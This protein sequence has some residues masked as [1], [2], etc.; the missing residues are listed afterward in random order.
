MARPVSKRKVGF[1]PENYS[2]TPDIVCPEGESEVIL[3]HDELESIRLSDVLNMEQNDAA[4]KLGISRGTFQR[5]LNSARK[6]TADALVY[7]RKISIAGGSY[8][9]QDCFAVCAD[10][11]HEWNASCDVLFYESQGKCPDCKSENIACSDGSG[12]CSLG[13]RRHIDM[14]SAHTR[15]KYV[16]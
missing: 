10:C 13:K 5:I 9:L 3:T 2:F 6:K 1:F 7:G 15:Q 11:G 12:K 16:R 14:L 8:R 4:Q